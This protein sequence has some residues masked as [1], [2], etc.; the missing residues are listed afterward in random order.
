[1]N[2]RMFSENEISQINSFIEKNVEHSILHKLFVYDDR[3]VEKIRVFSTIYRI[4]KSVADYLPDKNTREKMG[5]LLEPYGKVRQEVYHLISMYDFYKV[6][7]M[8][9]I[10][11]K[12]I[13][14][15]LRD[16]DSLDKIEQLCSDFLVM[17]E[18]HKTYSL[19]K[20]AGFSLET[21]EGKEL[22]KQIK[23]AM[24]KDKITY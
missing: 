2:I 8:K 1:M 4:C 6:T 5:K 12:R 16:Q 13:I 24:K 3:P 10:F 19:D 21:D 7:K 20:V 17:L 23:H 14:N 18:R 15:Y 9:L 22:A 11:H